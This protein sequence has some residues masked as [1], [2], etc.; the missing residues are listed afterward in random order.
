MSNT[1]QRLFNSGQFT[2][3]FDL[4]KIFLMNN[5]YENGSYVQNSNY[6]T[7]TLFAGTV[8]GRVTANGRIAPSISGVQD[9]SQIPIGVLAQD[10]TLLAGQQQ[11]V[12]ICVFGDVAAS[13]IIFIGGDSLDTITAGRRNQ[14]HLRIYGINWR[15]STL[16][17]DNDN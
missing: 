13:Q 6:S 5:R 15:F 10:V 8:M 3:G 4:S 17:T 7:L 12:S 16:M 14:D 1:R 9:G 2:L 11:V